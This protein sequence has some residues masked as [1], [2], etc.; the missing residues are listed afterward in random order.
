MQERY[1]W[2][3]Q[4]HPLVAGQL[5]RLGQAVQRANARDP[6][7]R[8]ESADLRLLAALRTVMFEQIPANPWRD[9]YRQPASA[10]MG[11]SRWLCATLGGGRFAVFFRIDPQAR[12]IVYGWIAD[13]SAARRPVIRDEPYVLFG[14]VCAVT[15][16]GRIALPLPVREVLQVAFGG[17]LS[18]WLQGATIFAGA[19]PPIGPAAGVFGE[20]SREKLRL[21]PLVRAVGLYHARLEDAAPHAG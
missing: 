10:A 1:G 12:R 3:L 15:P 18:F 16:K 19:M 17:R 9:D 13:R 21:A 20:R 2:R 14:T 11:R 4:A 5:E 6:F 8:R 7:N